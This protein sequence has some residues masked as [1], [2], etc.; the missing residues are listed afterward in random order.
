MALLF[1]GVSVLC[2]VL[3]AEARQR[4]TWLRQQAAA[5]EQ[6]VT[7]TPTV[8]GPLPE[9]GQIDVLGGP[10]FDL[11]GE[12]T[13]MALNLQYPRVRVRRVDAV[14]PSAPVAKSRAA[15]VVQY[16]DGR[17]ARVLLD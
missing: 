7:E 1:G 11:F 12:S 14:H 4:Q 2:V 15:C 16:D 13:R 10:V 17:Y 8:C 9:D 6:L 3:G 5:Y